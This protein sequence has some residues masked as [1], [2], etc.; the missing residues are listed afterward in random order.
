M[1]FIQDDF[2]RFVEENNVIGFFKEPITLKSGR[3]SNFYAN[4]RDIVEDVYLTDKL[5]DFVIEFAKKNNLHADTFFGVPEGATKI[6]IITQYKY[7]KLAN[8]FGKGSH[9]LS[10]GRAKPKEHGV[11]KDKFF[12]G[13]PRGRVVVI[14]DTTTTGGSLLTTL[15]M[16]KEAGITVTAVISLLNRME[17]RDDNLSVKEAVEK[18]GPKFYNMSAATQILPRVYKKLLP[19]E[20]IARAIEKGFEEFGVEKIKLI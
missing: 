2:N 10:I 5:A 9:T 8:N 11:P 7:A 1:A 14:E 16:L 12:V 6:G 18:R 15:D 20:E 17:K 3:K 4:W 13:A 19:G